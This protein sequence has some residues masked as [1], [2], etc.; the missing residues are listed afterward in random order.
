MLAMLMMTVESQRKLVCKGVMALLLFIFT[1]IAL[2][3]MV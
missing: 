1:L 2:F 3:N